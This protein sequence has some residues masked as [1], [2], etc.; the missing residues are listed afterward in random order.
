MLGAVDGFG[1]ADPVLITSYLS[2]DP[3]GDIGE[4]QVLEGRDRA[5]QASR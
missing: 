2:S 4:A 5:R 3:G 1:E